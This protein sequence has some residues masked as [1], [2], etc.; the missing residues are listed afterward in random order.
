MLFTPGFTNR[1]IL[2]GST[3]VVLSGLFNPSVLN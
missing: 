3:I 1:E 2:E